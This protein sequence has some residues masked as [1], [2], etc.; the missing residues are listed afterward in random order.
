MSRCNLFAKLKKHCGKEFSAN[1]KLQ[2]NHTVLTSLHYLLFIYFIIII[3]FFVCVCVCGSIVKGFLQML[4]CSIKPTTC[5][6]PSHPL[7]PKARI[8]V[9]SRFINGNCN[10][11]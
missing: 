10:A 5:I 1:L 8:A 3:F 2:K 11:T 6:H 9:S 4:F 7:L